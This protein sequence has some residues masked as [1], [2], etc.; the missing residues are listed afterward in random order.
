MSL[1][2]NIKT[3]S[4]TLQTNA[5]KTEKR[6]IKD[7]ENKYNILD[8]LKNEIE[9]AQDSSLD[10]FNKYDRECIERMRACKPSTW[11]ILQE[12]KYHKI[13]YSW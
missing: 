4:N 3:I 7:I 8:I 12:S 13:F 5:Q 2:N 9:A 6:S 10:I 11:W 1:N